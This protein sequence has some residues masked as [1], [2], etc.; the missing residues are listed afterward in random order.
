[1]TSTPTPRHPIVQKWLDGENDA[2]G[3]IAE[4]ETELA[5]ARA[6]TIAECAASFDMALKNDV[7]VPREP[8]E[9]AALPPLPHIYDAQLAPNGLRFQ[10]ILR[11]DYDALR[12]AAEKLVRE[13]DAWQNVASAGA[14]RAD[15]AEAKL[16]RYERIECEAGETLG[17]RLDMF[18]KIAG[19]LAIFIDDSLKANLAA[20]KKVGMPRV[21]MS[22]S[23]DDLDAA[24]AKLSRCGG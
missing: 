19:I 3:C 17:D 7:V 15:A 24:E 8:T 13:R 12:A 22:V 18:D 6:A 20:A 5:Q 1:M 21:T 16:A 4:L 10:G 11:K 9:S 2:G 23:V 14:E